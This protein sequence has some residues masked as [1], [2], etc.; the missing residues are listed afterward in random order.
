[1]LVNGNDDLPLS[2][3]MFAHKAARSVTAVQHN[4][5][6]VADVVVLLE[7]LG[8]NKDVIMKNGFEDQYDL[9]RY[10]YEFI[11][12]YDD[13]NAENSQSSLLKVPST[14]IRIVEGVSMMF[15]WLSSL[16]VLFISGVSLWMAWVLPAEVSTAFLAGVFIGLVMTEGPLQSSTRLFSFYYTQANMGEVKRIVKRNYSMIILILALIIVSLYAAGIFM[17]IPTSL[18]IVTAISTITISLHR[19]SYMIIYGTRKFRDFIPAYAGALA[20]LLVV[21]YTLP[22]L[23][24]STFPELVE[25]VT[26]RYFV[27]LGAAF[28]V[29]SIPA[30]YRHHEIMT[31]SSLSAMA[32]E[33]PH[34]FTPISIG[35]KTIKSRVGVQLWETTPYFLFGTFYLLM[36]FTDRI[37]S[38]FFNPTTVMEGA[39]LPFRLNAIYHA[40]ADP[41]LLVLLLASI[42]QYVMVAPI[43]EQ[44]NN[45]AVRLKATQMKEI[46]QFLQSRYM[47]IFLTSII[48]SVIVATILLFIAPEII[49]YTWGS[50]ISI[51]VLRVALISNI[52]MSIFILNSMFMILMKRVKTLAVIAI[53]ATLIVALGG[54]ILAHSGFENIVFAYLA[55]TMIAAITSALFVLKDIKYG[56]SIL[57]ARFV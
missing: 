6:T 48:P 15:P 21:Y 53:I 34:F 52:L 28:I 36:L 19:A 29:L 49:K 46:N 37:I 39:A 45:M 2:T 12:V 4:I 30:L 50:E 27:A 33:T 54:F 7:V 11:D 9:A 32:G 17:N 20:A 51:Y 26:M 55:S 10:I 56:S 25:D 8:Y 57:F 13:K 3:K 41:A 44:V 31:K 38:W 14:R 22:T 24:Y 16:A 40:G 23:V 18:L 43:Y 42:I 35:D 5:N 47:K 1:M